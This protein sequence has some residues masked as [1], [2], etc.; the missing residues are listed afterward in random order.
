MSRTHSQRRCAVFI[1]E[2][3]RLRSQTRLRAQGQSG[4][5]VTQSETHESGSGTRLWRLT[6]TLFSAS[7]ND[8][9]SE[10]S[11]NNRGGQNDKNSQ[12]KWMARETKQSLVPTK[13][14]VPD[15]SA[16]ALSR[17]EHHRHRAVRLVQRSLLIV[18]RHRRSCKASYISF[19]LHF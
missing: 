16:S 6:H 5:A 1:N 4:A 18:R 13:L 11:T 12:L 10:E 14:I 2:S 8:A 17:F 19:I 7:K 15:W 3:R 9:H